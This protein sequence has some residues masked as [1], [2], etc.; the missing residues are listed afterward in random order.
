MSKSK[1]LKALVL[2][3]KDQ[4]EVFI[5]G[6]F[7]AFCIT[8][9]KWKALISGLEVTDEKQ[10]DKMKMSRKARLELQKVRTSAS[11]VKNELK[12][13]SI[14]YGKAVQQV[15]NFIEGEIKPMEK[16]LK[17]N[18]DFVKIKEEKRIQ[19]IEDDQSQAIN[20]ENL[21]EYISPNGHL[22]ADEFDAL[23]QLA[24]K[25]KAKAEAEEKERI[26][27]VKIAEERLQKI[28]KLE[29]EL[30]QK[31]EPI[32]QPEPIKHEGIE[33]CFSTI[34]NLYE[35]ASDKKKEGVVTLLKKI[36]KWL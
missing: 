15:Y 12:K 2:P 20:Q 3:V 26:N 5:K 24:S 36:I 18:E 17:E 35:N 34:R 11:K 14:A 10:K 19:A 9:E 28:K 33:A 13:E 30:E 27:A 25:K 6:E 32:K 23:F 4:N 21:Q 1:E 22:D 29:K 31:P 16:S 7:E 8:V